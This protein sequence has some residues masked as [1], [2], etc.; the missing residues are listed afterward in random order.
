MLSFI[1]DQKEFHLFD[2]MKVVFNVT[3]HSLVN[4]VTMRVLE[5][6]G[7]WTENWQNPTHAELKA[8]YNFRTNI[9]EFQLAWMSIVF[10][11]A[12][13]TITPQ[14][15][16]SGN[17]SDNSNSFTFWIK[18]FCFYVKLNPEYLSWLLE[19]AKAT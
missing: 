5:M 2:N 11:L 8:L 15:K 16:P 14:S 13:N 7:V 6:G 4:D 9:K 12:Q 18:I 3:W 19:K 10:A 17:L 1:G